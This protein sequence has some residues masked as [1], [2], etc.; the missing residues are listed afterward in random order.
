M[1]LDFFP[2]CCRQNDYRQPALG[3]ILLMTNALVG[4]NHRVK[5]KFGR[6]QQLT[7]IYLAPSHFV[8]GRYRMS[9]QCVPKRRRS[10]VVKQYPHMD[11]NVIQRDF[12]RR[13]AVRV[14]LV[15][16]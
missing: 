7:V 10:A 6:R 2:I 14:R 12:V 15:P 3:Q 4:R 5:F 1:H 9:R 8:S 16:V 11:L 13:D